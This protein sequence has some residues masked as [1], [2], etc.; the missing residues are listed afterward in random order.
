MRYLQKIIVIS[1]LALWPHLAAAQVPS[2]SSDDPLRLETE[3]TA[4]PQTAVVVDEEQAEIRFIIDGREAA[5]LN[6]TGLHVR[7]GVFYGA[8]ITDYGAEGYE[9]LSGDGRDER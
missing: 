8:G 9:A 4:Q 2:S 1:S 5:R 7:D 3:Q 6:A